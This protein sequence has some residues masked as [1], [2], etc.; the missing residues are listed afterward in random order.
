MPLICFDLDGTL[1]DPFPAVRH[2]MDILCQQQSLPP[3]P[4]EVLRAHI[5]PGAPRLIASLGLGP[6]RSAEALRTYWGAF[7][8]EGIQ[9]HRIYEGVHLMLNHLRHQGHHLA[10]LTAKPTTLA[11][12]V[13]HH[14]DVLLLFDHILGTD[15]EGPP[16]TKEALLQSL[17]AQGEG[18]QGGCLVGDRGTDM[19]AARAFNLLPLGVAYGYGSPEELIKG[20]AARVFPGVRDLECWF[21][22]QF[23]EPEIVD[24]FSHSE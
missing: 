22:E 12:Q 15:L 11:R 24:S 10:I 17:A 21:R 7:Q 16:Q 9:R 3:V 6:V 20:G 18:L 13:A 8:A 4:D 1:V 23:P 2:C 14:F 19:E 5:G